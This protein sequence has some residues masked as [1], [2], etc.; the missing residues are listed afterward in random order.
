MPDLQRNS[1]WCLYASSQS[2]LCK[3][4]C[5][6][7]ENTVLTTHLPKT[8][9]GRQAPELLPNTLCGTGLCL[10]DFISQTIIQFIVSGIFLD[11]LEYSRSKIHSYFLKTWLPGDQMEEQAVSCGLDPCQ[12]L[13]LSSCKPGSFHIFFK[14]H[15]ISS[16]NTYYINFSLFFLLNTIKFCKNCACHQETKIIGKKITKYSNCHCLSTWVKHQLFSALELE[17]S[18]FIKCVFSMYLSC[19][20][21]LEETL[22]SWFMNHEIL[23]FI[24]FKLLSK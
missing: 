14:A 24:D 3:I 17:W 23:K 18:S 5:L 7:V 20:S 15:S 16:S 9:Y 21:S 22:G 6:D 13:S 8:M 4:P 19:F 12:N 10:L 11:T 1:S 2:Y